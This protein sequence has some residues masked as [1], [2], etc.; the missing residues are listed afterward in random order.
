MLS[1]LSPR[2][3]VCVTPQ[4]SVAP[5]LN[6]Q[7]SNAR[8]Y[9]F[10]WRSIAHAPL[11]I[12]NYVAYASLRMFL[13]KRYEW[14]MKLREWT[15]TIVIVWIQ[16]QYS[17]NLFLRTTSKL[18]KNISTVKPMWFTLYEVKTKVPLHVWSITCS[19]SGGAIQTALGILRARYV[20]WIHQDW[21]GTGSFA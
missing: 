12:K 17:D 1:T 15:L 19:S 9:I 13:Y 8:R 3:H 7:P 14:L 10:Y 4:C 5:S 11:K 6:L 18:N 2:T 20:S 16:W 21:S